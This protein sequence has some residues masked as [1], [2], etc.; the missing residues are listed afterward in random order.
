MSSC[1]IEPFMIVL[2]SATANSK[3]STG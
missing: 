1:H 3:Y 2:I